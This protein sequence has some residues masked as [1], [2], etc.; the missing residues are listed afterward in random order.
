[1]L[2]LEWW[3]IRR[4]VSCLALGLPVCVANAQDAWLTLLGDPSQAN[5][6]TIQ[7][8]PA[9]IESKGS[10]RVLKVRVS[11]ALPRTSWDGVPYQ[12]YES[13][14]VFDC[15]KRTARYRSIDYFAQPLWAGKAYRSVDYT[16]GEPRWMLFREVEPNPNVRIINA[17]CATAAR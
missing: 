14:V 16:Q 4:I 7:V 11:R 2:Q 9:A 6:N 1:L 10:I 12:S 8:E 5:T 15:E 13:F 3:V 17:A